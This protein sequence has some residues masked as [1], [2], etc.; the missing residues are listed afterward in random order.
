MK[1]NAT[2]SSN[3]A[4]RADKITMTA[5]YCGVDFIIIANEEQNGVV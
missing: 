5:Y 4:W 2:A 3:I 1:E